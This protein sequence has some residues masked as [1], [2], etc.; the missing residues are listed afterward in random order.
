[1]IEEYEVVLL[2]DKGSHFNLSTVFVY[3][4]LLTIKPT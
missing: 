3:V 2:Q 4:I 1:M